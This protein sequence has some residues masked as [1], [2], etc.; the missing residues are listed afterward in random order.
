M[1]AKG[2]VRKLCEGPVVL[3]GIIL[4]MRE[5]QRWI[6]VA[7]QRLENIF[8]LRPLKGEIAVLKAYGPQLDK[9]FA[10]FRKAAALS[11]ASMA[12]SPLPLNTIH[13][14]DRLGISLIRRR[15]TPRSQFRYR[16]SAHPSKED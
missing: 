10:S 4:P 11:R 3:M 5:H 13:R 1:V 12:R 15:I 14:I 6:E 2:V 16:Q 7:F 8:D 9:F